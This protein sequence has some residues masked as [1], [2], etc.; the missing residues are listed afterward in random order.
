MIPT[1]RAKWV[2]LHFFYKDNPDIIDNWKKLQPL[3]AELMAYFNEKIGPYP[4]KQYAVVHGG[5]GMEYAMLHSL[6]AIE[7][8]VRWLG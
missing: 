4:Y 7:N 6:R 3:T 1:Q 2:T 5:D 8:L